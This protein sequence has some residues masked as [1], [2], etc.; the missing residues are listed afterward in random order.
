MEN[1]IGSW[2]MYGQDEKR[3]YPV[4]QEEFFNR[5]GQALNRRESML[6][7]CIIWCSFTVNLGI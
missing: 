4:M 7:F 3:R 2:D 1:T 5:A 6:A